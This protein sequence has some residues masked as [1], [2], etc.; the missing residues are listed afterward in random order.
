MTRGILPSATATATATVRLQLVGAPLL[1]VG[2][3]THRFTAERRFQL[4]ALLAMSCGQWFSRYRLAALLWPARPYDQARRNPR[5][6]I[7]RLH[8]CRVAPR[9]R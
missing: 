1:H 6:V 2:E 8:E 9:W 4:L 7:L 3:A 5:N